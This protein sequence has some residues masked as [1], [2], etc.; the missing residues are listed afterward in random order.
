MSEGRYGNPILEE[1]LRRSWRL[2]AIQG[3]TCVGGLITSI[4]E[5]EIMGMPPEGGLA[6]EWWDGSK[7]RTV[8]NTN[9]IGPERGGNLNP[10]LATSKV[11]PVLRRELL[12]DDLADV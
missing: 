5:V 11:L 3:R 12:L 9:Y 10:E 8:L 2:L 1:L 6:V 4:G 7:L